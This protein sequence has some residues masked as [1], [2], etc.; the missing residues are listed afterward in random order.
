MPKVKIGEINKL[1]YYIDV[2]YY[3]KN[4]AK[5]ILLWDLENWQGPYHHILLK[6]MC[7]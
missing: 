1:E 5:D 4:K 3:I 7:K 2:K 6:I